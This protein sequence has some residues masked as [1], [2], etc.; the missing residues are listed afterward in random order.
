MNQNLKL[1]I[2][3]ILVFLISMSIGMLVTNNV[4]HN[5]ASLLHSSGL[6]NNLIYIHPETISGAEGE[7]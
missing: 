5:E 7:H 1:I 4:V 2:I 6:E 3:A